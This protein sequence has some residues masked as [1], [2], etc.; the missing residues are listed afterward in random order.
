MSD[1]PD[2]LTADITTMPPGVRLA[3]A[4]SDLVFEN[5]GDLTA[6]GYTD[7]YFSRAQPRDKKGRWTGPG[8]IG[9]GIDPAMGVEVAAMEAGLFAGQ[10]VRCAPSRIDALM[11]DLPN[12]PVS[13]LEHLDVT[14]PGNE[15]LF[16]KHARE[17]PRKEMPQIPETA[18]GMAKFKE[19]L[20]SRKAELVEVDP[21]TLT[22]T[23]NQ[24]VSANVGKLYGY[25]QDGGWREDSILFASKNGEIVDG[26]HRWAA[27]SAV[28]ATG[29]PIKV[30]VL[31]IDSDID[32]ILGVAESVSG[33]HASMSSIIAAA[34]QID[35]DVPTSPPPNLYEPW[36]WFDGQWWYVVTDTGDEVPTD[37]S[38][39]DVRPQQ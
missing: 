23:Q 2:A 38:I 39:L 20:G 3:W 13:N 25:I 4:P 9:G 26:H 21:R 29:K 30:K 35:R 1:D 28:A 18:E 19:A 22:A 7:A 17:I 16:T 24:L 34:V 14:G 27:A 11:R 36:F 12:R 31:K 15:N 10:T 8:A 33:E 37:L 32:D 6:G 5:E